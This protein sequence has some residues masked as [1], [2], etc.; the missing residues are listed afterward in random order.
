MRL[1]VQNG[2]KRSW[3]RGLKRLISS[4]PLFSICIHALSVIHIGF[5][6]LSRPLSPSLSHFILL[7]LSRLFPE[8]TYS[9]FLLPAFLS[10]LI[11]FF[12]LSLSLSSYLPISPTATY[13]YFLENTSKF[14]GIWLFFQNQAF[15]FFH[16]KLKMM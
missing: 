11:S 15:L 3:R 4:F 10:P 14:F 7:F 9:C 16:Q 8:V 2:G 13:S 12:H 5:R 6:F 1:L